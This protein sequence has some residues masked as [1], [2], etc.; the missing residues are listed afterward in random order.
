MPHPIT[1]ASDTALAELAMQAIARAHRGERVQ[2]VFD[3]DDTLFLVHPRKRAIFREL[4]IDVGDQPAA[5]AL[6]RLASSEIPYDVKAALGT[7]GITEPGLVERLTRGFFDRFFD[8]AYTRHDAPNDGAA[9]FLA[10]LHARGVRVVYL[11][12]RPEEMEPR[13]RHTL[14]RHGFPLDEN[15]ALMLK[16]RH[17]SH[18]GDA[19]FKGVKAREI[20]AW[21]SV[22]A[23]FDNEPANLNAMFDAA[24][25]ARYFL[26]DTDHSPNPPVPS[27]AVQVLRDFAQARAHLETSLAGSPK[28]GRGAWRLDVQAGA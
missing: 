21:G 11:T 22:L 6:E 10:H 1:P 7:V 16:G 20:A 14:E 2:V 23:V 26:L 8:G 15:T 27:M 18:L 24:P 9:A 5:A 28:F 3:L 4:A 19:E 25:A 12:G 13:T 17:E